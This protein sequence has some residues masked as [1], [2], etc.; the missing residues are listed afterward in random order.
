M[1]SGRGIKELQLGE[2]Y[3]ASIETLWSVVKAHPDTDTN[4]PL[5]ADIEARLAKPNKTWSDVYALE[6]LI[7]PL[8]PELEITAFF[9]RRLA[10]AKT[11]DLPALGAHEANWDAAKLEKDH[12]ERLHAK[13]AAYFVLLDDL[14]W[15]HT[16]Q[17][18]DRS[19]RD[20]AAQRLWR[21]GLVVLALVALPWTV[22]GSLGM[23]ASS[24][25]AAKSLLDAALAHPPLFGFYTAL[26]FGLLG[27]VF[28]RLA[29]FQSN[30]ATLT[31]A[32]IGQTFKLR[33]LMVRFGFGMVGAGILYFL[34]AGGFLTGSL[35]PNLKT[36]KFVDSTVPLWGTDWVT[37]VPN[38]EFA[39]LVVWSFL[40]GFSERFV[41][42]T[43]ERSVG[44]AQAAE[45]KQED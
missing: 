17:R 24:T 38:A 31:H 37:A 8:M 39:K 23:M 29:S 25:P 12:D 33:Y 18:L 32:D 10:R 7:V 19:H 36:A 22:V 3:I 40:G 27:A 6:R 35:F 20:Q 21:V 15:Y 34:M 9:Q 28:S 11:L 30:V 1:T 14:N 42:G 5:A 2:Y 26:S 41:S 4:S 13:Q 45:N 44:N 43:L 16:V